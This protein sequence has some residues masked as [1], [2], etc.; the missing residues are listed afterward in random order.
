[1]SSTPIPPSLKKSSSSQ[2]SKNQ[3]S[4]V[5]FFQKKKVESSP[6]NTPPALK[7]NNL[8]ARSINTEKSNSSKTL[9]RDLSQ[10][11]TPA[12][13]SDTIEEDSSE[14]KRESKEGL[15]IK[16]NGL[17]SPLTPLSD[18]APGTLPVSTTKVTSN[19]DS[20]SRKVG[21]PRVVIYLK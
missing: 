7:N 5:G 17:P 8:P 15:D 1:M 19:F 6:S 13:S 2:S 16:D 20:P 12:P 4:I 21:F 14:E 3:K 9:A 18:A 10:S 11:L